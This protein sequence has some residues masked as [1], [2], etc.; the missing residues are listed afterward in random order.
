MSPD[1]TAYSRGYLDAVLT[2][3]EVCDRTL[4]FED[5]PNRFPLEDRFDELETHAVRQHVQAMADELGIDE[6]GWVVM[7]PGGDG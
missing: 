4:S 7:R 1:S 3:R 5:D 2:V 6:D